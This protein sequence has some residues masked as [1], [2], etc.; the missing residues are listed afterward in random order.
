[1]RPPEIHVAGD[2]LFLHAAYP[3][4][5]NRLAL[6]FPA[7]LELGAHGE[8]ASGPVRHQFVVARLLGTARECVECEDR[9]Q[10]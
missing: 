2:P 3:G 6:E 9:I 7:A 10:R 5:R 1:M 4:R 8:R